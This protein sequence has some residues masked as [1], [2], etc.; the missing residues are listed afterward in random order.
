M[1]KNGRLFGI[2]VL[3]L[4]AGCAGSNSAEPQ[5]QWTPNYVNVKYRA[6]PVDIAA[7]YFESLGRSDSSVVE[8]AWFDS[9]NEYLVINLQ[10]TVYHYCG[11]GSSTW[12]SLKS[13]ESM[14]SYFQDSIKGNFDC[15]VFPVPAYP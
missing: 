9:E 12:S 14:G 10:G 3:L 1:L 7:P 11:I 13:A 8:G 6:D 5:Q 2:C 4:L 15:R